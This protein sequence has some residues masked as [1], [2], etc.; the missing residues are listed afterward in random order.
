[1]GFDYGTV[2][3]TYKD[4]EQDTAENQAVERE[5]T[6][7]AG[8]EITPP[9]TTSVH[10]GHLFKDGSCAWTEYYT[11]QKILEKVGRL[12][13]QDFELFGWYDLHAWRERLYSCLN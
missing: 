9:L 4:A 13:S 3:R 2:A 12:Y 7:E 8:G 5:Q 6:G 1:M 10:A 11:D